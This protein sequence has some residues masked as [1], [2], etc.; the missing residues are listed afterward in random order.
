MPHV[1]IPQ[2]FCIAGVARR[3]I[4]PPMGIYH[5]MWGAATHERATG[6]HRPLNVTAL[7]IAPR[8]DETPASSGPMPQVL[9]A[10]DHCLLWNEDMESLRRAVCRSSRISPDQLHVAFSH[11]HAAGLMDRGRST[12]AGGELIG[13][14]LDRV[15]EMANDAIA[16]AR[17]LMEPAKIVYGSGHCTLAANRDFHDEASGQFVCGF[18]PD[19]PTDDT[20]LVARIKDEAGGALATV[21]NYACHP[22]TLAWQNTLVSPD[23]VGAMREVVEAATGS[24]CMFLQGAS[25]DLGPRHGYVGDVEV[26]DRNGR[27]LG[28]AVLSVLQSLPD[29]GVRFEY[30]GPVVSGATLGTWDYRPLGPDERR[31]KHGIHCRR[32]DVELPYRDD[33]PTREQTTAALG[34]WQTA[35]RAALDA[36]DLD[37]ARDAHAQIERM[38]RQLS[39][40]QMLPDGK[41]VP[42]GVSLWQLGDAIWVML[43]GE[44]YHL[45]Q[46]SL[47]ERF[48]P[49]P[50]LVATVT[51][52]WRPGYLPTR[53][54]YG[55]GIYQESI[56][57]VAPGSLEQLIEAIGGEIAALSAGS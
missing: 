33:L 34:E 43:Q 15:A 7:V 47:R 26:V 10:V 48:A 39:R 17:R 3:D 28:Y 55:R 51:D 42:L 22:T 18:N 45:L 53:E 49:R 32:F 52:G 54:T 24:V 16:E 19:G 14:Y 6:V 38:S 12:L 31:R 21:V 5:R 2:S 23:Y 37:A 13:P 27:Q 20:L 4:T 56:A 9:L 46:R 35:Q 36:G 1:E 44:H 57:I 41:T 11:T 29:A 8:G 30:T 40:L 50:V 25:G